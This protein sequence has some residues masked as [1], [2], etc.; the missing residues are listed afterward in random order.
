MTWA[1]G[2]W[3][4]G[5]PFHPT[6]LVGGGR[7]ALGWGLTAFAIEWF[8]SGVRLVAER[9]SD[10][11]AQVDTSVTRQTNPHPPPSSLTANSSSLLPS[12]REGRPHRNRPLSVPP[13]FH[14]K[15]CP[16]RG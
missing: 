15:L 8:A 10:G 9:P 16:V 1:G 14:C 5:A 13:H 6:Q 12:S 7:R 3:P 4:L 2:S 11:F